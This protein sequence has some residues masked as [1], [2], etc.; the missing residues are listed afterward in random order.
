MRSPFSASIPLDQLPRLLL[1]L[2]FH[3]LRFRRTGVVFRQLL[4]FLVLL[5]LELLPLLCLL[6][7]D[8]ILLLLEFLI[9]L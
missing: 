1:V 3:L 5:L 9:S 4:M 6:C 7:D 8:F 2:L